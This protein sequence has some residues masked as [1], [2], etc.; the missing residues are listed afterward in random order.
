MKAFR[1]FVSLMFLVLLSGFAQKPGVVWT[2]YTPEKMEAAR[3]SGKPVAAYFYAAWCHSCYN[4][5]NETFTDPQVIQA[6]E[7]FQRIKV[8]MSFNRSEKIQKIANEFG[9]HGFPTLIFFDAGGK[10]G[11][12]VSGFVS[13]KQMLRLIKENTRATVTTMQ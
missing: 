2:D 7:S 13:A 6:L 11:R 8:D 4:L 10:A 3:A 9:I 5:K 12:R 1:I